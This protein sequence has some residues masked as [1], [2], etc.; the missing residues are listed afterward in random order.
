VSSA[1]PSQPSAYLCCTILSL[2]TLIITVEA[3]CPLQRLHHTVMLC[4][5][6][7]HLYVVHNHVLI[8]TIACIPLS[9]MFFICGLP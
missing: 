3:S 5:Q 8:C 6:Q 1:V 4:G 7:H 2:K 9:G